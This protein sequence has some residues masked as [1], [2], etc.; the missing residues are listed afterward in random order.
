MFVIVEING[1]Y[2]LKHNA[3]IEDID[4]SEILKALASLAIY[5]DEFEARL[6]YDD[7]L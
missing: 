5:A 4:E 2:A 3:F 6:G 1:A 7:E